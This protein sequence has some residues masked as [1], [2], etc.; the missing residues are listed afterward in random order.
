MP[1]EGAECE[2]SK[3][4]NVIKPVKHTKLISRKQI[5]KK[6]SSSNLNI[7]N[8]IGSTTSKMAFKVNTDRRPPSKYHA[9]ELMSSTVKFSQ[10][11]GLLQHIDSESVQPHLPII[12]DVDISKF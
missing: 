12:C 8:L 1:N 7:K 11:D 2:K 6:T 5:K 4:V 3:N 9:G 10:G